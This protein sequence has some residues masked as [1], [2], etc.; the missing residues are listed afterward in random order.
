MALV[1]PD[2]NSTA[3]IR[4]ADYT[5]TPMVVNFWSSDCP[6]CTAEMPTLFQIA[7]TEAHIQFLGVAI[8][9]RLQARRFLSRQMITYPQL[10][11]PKDSDGIMRRFGDPKG[12]LPYTVVLDRSHR[13]CQSHVGAIDKS[14][15]LAAIRACSI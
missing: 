4:L 12:V 13:T 10:L 15:L 6:P 11:A 8:D 14:W 5:G 7:R 1:L 2:I 3:F 9:D